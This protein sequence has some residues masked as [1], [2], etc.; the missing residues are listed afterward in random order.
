MDNG[1]RG[2]LD[3]Y[4]EDEET[5]DI[6]EM[7]HQFEMTYNTAPRTLSK[8]TL[9]SRAE[10]IREELDELFDAIER[11]DYL[12]MVDALVDIVV[13]VKGTVA[14]LGLRWR[15]HWREVHRANMSKQRGNNPKR[16]ELKEDLIK[17]E[18]WMGPDHLNV[19]TRYRDQ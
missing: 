13:V 17:P 1:V 7:H 10:F 2:K 14:M 6:A 12:A 9:K 11:N 4:F 16:P 15:R 3:K 18:G 5:A 19:L 8:D